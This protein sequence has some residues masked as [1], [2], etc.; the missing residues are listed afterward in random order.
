VGR[1]ASLRRRRAD[2]AL[3]L[4]RKSARPSSRVESA[5]KVQASD[6]TFDGAAT[7]PLYSNSSTPRSFFT[8]LSLAAPVQKNARDKGYLSSYSNEAQLSSDSEEIEL[9]LG[10][11]LHQALVALGAIA[12]QVQRR[13]VEASSNL[14]RSQ[15]ESANRKGIYV[16]GKERAAHEALHVGDIESVLDV[17]VPARAVVVFRGVVKAQET[18]GSLHER[19]RRVSGSSCVADERES[20][21]KSSASLPR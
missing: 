14:W 12:R 9:A 21:P 20:S 2:V 7:K 8:S 13:D 3:R 16:R 4:P 11:H 6:K 5:Q 17:L 18:V 1:R 19:E 15:T 10:V